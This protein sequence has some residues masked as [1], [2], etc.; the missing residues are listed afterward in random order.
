MHHLC[1]P[2]Q[3]QLVRLA[4]LRLPLGLWRYAA[5]A[6]PHLAWSER[7]ACCRLRAAGIVR[8]ARC[9]GRASAESPV[10]ARRAVVWRRRRVAALPGIASVTR[11][12]AA[13][14]HERRVRCRCVTYTGAS[15]DG[16]AI[17][18]ARRQ[19]ADT[20]R[21]VRSEGVLPT[22][23]EI[24]GPSERARAL[25]PAAR[26]RSVYVT[27]ERVENRTQEH[28]RTPSTSLR[29]C[30]SAPWVFR[31]TSTACSPGPASRPTSLAHSRRDARACGGTH[32]PRHTQRRAAPAHQPPSSASFKSSYSPKAAVR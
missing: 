29:R 10:R 20:L 24:E 13:Q 8:A 17:A 16:R 31:G 5:A 32:S 21:N 19:S 25:A 11:A 28:T 23:A 12:C 3:T 30:H 18:I 15:R 22:P 27:Y 26:S 6:R 4:K 1:H 7:G 9:G 14:A 2:S